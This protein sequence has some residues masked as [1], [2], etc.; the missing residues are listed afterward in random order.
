MSSGRVGSLP[1]KKKKKKKKKKRRHLGGKK[2]KKKMKSNVDKHMCNW[3]WA[4]L[5]K[6]DVQFFP[7]IFFSIFG[8]KF[9]G[10][11]EKKTYASPYLFS[12]NPTKPNTL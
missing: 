2:K 8:R 4:F 9:F 6:N 5:S 3:T 1:K 7:S 11:P 10:R 12:F